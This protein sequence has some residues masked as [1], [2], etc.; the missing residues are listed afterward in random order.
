[1]DCPEYMDAYLSA[2]GIGR[3][4]PT[5]KHSPLF[6]TTVRKEKRLTKNSMTA[7][8]MCRMFKRRL[9]DAGLPDPSKS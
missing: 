1:M 2:A 8:N 4:D 6:R 5:L 3:S 9:K 7:H